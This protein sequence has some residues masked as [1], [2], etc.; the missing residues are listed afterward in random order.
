[1]GIVL[2]ADQIGEENDSTRM[3]RLRK[4][5]VTVEGRILNEKVGTLHLDPTLTVIYLVSVVK[6]DF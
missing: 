5:Q 1:M 2:N 3:S 6:L 4:K